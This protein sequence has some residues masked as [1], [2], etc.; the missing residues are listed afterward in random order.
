M[1]G[2]AGFVCG[3]C[4]AVAVVV[5]G[6]GWGEGDGDLVAEDGCVDGVFLGGGPEVCWSADD[7]PA[8]WF[9]VQGGGLWGDVGEGAALDAVG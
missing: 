5:V 9:H 1:P 8:V 7:C 3:L 6:G 4:G 2:S